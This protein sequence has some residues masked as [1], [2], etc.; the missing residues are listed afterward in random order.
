LFSGAATPYAPPPW[1]PEP[2][3]LNAPTS[4]PASDFSIGGILGPHL[5]A[6]AAEANGLGGILGPVAG[7]FSPSPE[8]TG[9]TTA[10]GSHPL[11]MS[12]GQGQIPFGP[13]AGNVFDKPSELN[14]AVPL[15]PNHDINLPQSP[16]PASSPQFGDTTAPR[17]APS[18]TAWDETFPPT[19]RSLGLPGVFP[20]GNSGV[21]RDAEASNPWPP[22]DVGPGKLGSYRDVGDLY[23][24]KD[25]VDRF[26]NR[27]PNLSPIISDAPED[28][29]IPGARYVQARGRRGGG[30]PGEPERSTAETVRFNIYNHNRFMLRELDPQNPLITTQ[31]I[32]TR[33]WVPSARDNLLLEREID[34]L[35]YERGLGL[36]RHHNLVKEFENRFREC[37]LEPEEYVTY[38]PRDMH[39]FLPDGAHTG[40][41]NWNSQWRQ[42][43]QTQ[44]SRKPD[45]E[46]ILMQLMKMWKDVPWLKR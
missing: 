44:G 36:E 40:P 19:Y 1:A 14:L 45:P 31:F 33:D 12:F 15:G 23:P 21:G 17:S 30:R 11:A 13:A 34:R 42:Y 38:L 10:T 20:L 8:P 26:T 24:S 18:G 37:G 27:P 39:R 9:L 5:A 28:S 4:Y 46:E 41:N 2:N 6:R 16:Q 32:S 7:Q 3:D 43:F 29:W 35:R 25:T 22:G